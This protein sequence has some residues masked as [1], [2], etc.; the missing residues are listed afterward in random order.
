MRSAASKRNRGGRIRRAGSRDPGTFRLAIFAAV[1]VVAASA[2]LIG[3]FALFR[4]SSG[5]PKPFT[6][7]TAAGGTVSVPDPDRPT[8]LVF[9][10]GFF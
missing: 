1:A 4:D 8:V 2:V 5:N 9:Y 7:A 10:R 3:A 6:A